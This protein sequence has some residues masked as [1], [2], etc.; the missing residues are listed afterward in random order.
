MRW[1]ECVGSSADL[2]GPC[3]REVSAARPRS[4]FGWRGSSKYFA[5]LNEETFEAKDRFAFSALLDGYGCPS[6]RIGV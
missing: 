1:L 3:A 6:K 5:S 4:L 2:G